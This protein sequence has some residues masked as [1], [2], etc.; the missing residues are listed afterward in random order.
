MKIF[1][2]ILTA[3]T[4]CALL[5]ACSLASV[6]EPRSVLADDIKKTDA[7]A[8]IAAV[9]ELSADGV[10]DNHY[11]IAGLET[12]IAAGETGLI[13]ARAETLFDR[14]AA[15]MRDGLTSRDARLNWRM[16]EAAPDK[17]AMADLK[18]H[19]FNGNAFAEAFSSLAPKHKQYAFLK[20]ALASQALTAEEAALLRL[21]M[22]RWRWMP[23]DLGGDY[24]L[25]N[26]PAFELTLVRDRKVV[27]RRRVVTG[28]PKL[29]TPQMQALVTGVIFNPTWFVPPSI[30][31]ESVGALIK[32]NPDRA[33]QL[34]YYVGDDGN[35]RQKPGP[36]NALGQ[37]KLVMPNPYSVFLHDTPA[38]DAFERDNRALSHGCI[39]VE[40]ATGF[41]RTLLGDA[42]SDDDFKKIMSGRSPVEIELEKPLPVYVGYFTAVADETGRIAFY[43]DVYGLDAPLL[44][45]FGGAGKDIADSIGTLIEESCPESISE[46]SLPDEL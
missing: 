33:Q 2:V 11:D 44:A 30:V 21:N 8:L 27:A 4:A 18:Q 24:I 17:A 6:G 39:R 13:R 10:P 23:D 28:S 37:M 5:A 26:V 22:D 36:A 34:G 7:D 14:V 38:K 41:A 43:P 40:G 12:V 19:A 15:E 45:Q 25:V 32:N 3:Y 35:V 42:V 9:K 16:D 20:A 1:A 29:P 31:R 46:A